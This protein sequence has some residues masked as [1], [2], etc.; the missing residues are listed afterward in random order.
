MEAALLARRIVTVIEARRI[1]MTTEEAAHRAISAAL[2]AAG[3]EHENEVRL[4]KGE[5]IDML[6]GRVGIEVKVQG[7]RRAIYRQLE[8]YVLR[9]EIDALVLVTGVAFP[10]SLDVEGRTVFIANLTRGWL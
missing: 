7:Q 4:S 5:R 9:P 1:N 8:R 6:A 2:T 10:G 3:I